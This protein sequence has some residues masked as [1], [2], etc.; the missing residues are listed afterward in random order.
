[1]ISQPPA[2]TNHS[3]SNEYLRISW[4]FALQPGKYSGRDATHPKQQVSIWDIADIMY[5]GCI[6]LRALY[7]RGRW[8]W[9]YSDSTVL[10]ISVQVSVQYSQITKIVESN[11]SLK[12]TRQ[13]LKTD[14][15][16]NTSFAKAIS[17]LVAIGISCPWNAFWNYIWYCPSHCS[18]HSQFQVI[19]FPSHNSSETLL[20]RVFWTTLSLKTRG[21]TSQPIASNYKC[22]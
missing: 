5:F 4:K 14:S 8:I 3:K 12:T 15:R 11:L 18:N 1:M 19:W 22:K 2:S 17:R 10:W 9:H 21:R 16:S 7:W 20:H 6:Y 13:I